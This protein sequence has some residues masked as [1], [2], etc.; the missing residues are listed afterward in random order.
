MLRR[1][2]RCSGEMWYWTTWNPRTDFF[3]A[4][5]SWPHIQTQARQKLSSWATQGWGAT[6]PIARALMHREGWHICS[7]SQ[8]TLQHVLTR[9]FHQAGQC[10]RTMKPRGFVGASSALESSFQPQSHPLPWCPWML[11]LA[12]CSAQVPQGGSGCCGPFLQLL[13]SFV[14]WQLQ[15]DYI[16]QQAAL[17]KGGRKAFPPFFLPHYIPPQWNGKTILTLLTHRVLWEDKRCKAARSQLN[18]EVGRM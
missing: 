11:P 14:P 8:F 13:H 5:V 1:T 17:G 7:L 4:P 12:S 6:I 9:L 15:L 16:S 3:P 2:L 10:P 18:P